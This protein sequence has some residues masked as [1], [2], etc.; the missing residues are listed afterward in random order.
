MKL[1]VTVG[2]TK[3]DSLIRAVDHVLDGYAKC[4]SVFQIA[5]GEYIPKNGQYFDYIENIEQHYNPSDL[6]ITHAGAGT[7]YR[8]LELDK[9]IIVVPNLDRVD[10]HQVDISNFMELGGH[11]LVARNVDSIADCMEKSREFAPVRFH[12]VGFF[13]AKNIADFIK[14]NR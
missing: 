5:D 2:T 9:K 4:D 6:V 12:K 10:K 13:K 14:F 11:L 8:L 3:F 1:L 7:I